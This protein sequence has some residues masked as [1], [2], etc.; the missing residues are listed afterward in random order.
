MV[1]CFLL[2][3]LCGGMLQKE[4]PQ[5]CWWLK[6]TQENDGNR[7]MKASSLTEVGQGV[8]FDVRPHV[9][10]VNAGPWCPA[11]A[12]ACW[13]WRR[14]VLSSVGELQWPAEGYPSSSGSYKKD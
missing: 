10:A 14:V 8:W 7:V 11:L 1:C 12:G 6:R 3:E 5:Q 13:K 9:P 4:T 2:E